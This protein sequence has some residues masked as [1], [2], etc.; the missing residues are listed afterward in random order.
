MV[1]SDAMVGCD[2]G[3]ECGVL[4]CGVCLPLLVCESEKED[5]LEGTWRKRRYGKG[6]RERMK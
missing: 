5:V 1:L 6:G 2:D 4:E 3:E